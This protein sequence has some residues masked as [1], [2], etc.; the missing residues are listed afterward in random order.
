MKRVLSLALAA[1]LIAAAG[2]DDGN[3]TSCGAD[4]QLCNGECAYTNND[5]DNCGGCGNACGS[6]QQCSNSQ[7]VCAGGLTICGQDC[8]TLGREDN[9]SGCGDV[10]SGTEACV[11]GECVT[12]S[13]EECNGVDDDGDDQIDE[14]LSQP[15]VTSCGEGIETCVAGAW[16]DCD[17][18]EPGT[19]VCDED[20]NDCDGEVDEGVTTTYYRDADGDRYGSATDSVQDC[21][22]P[23]GYVDDRTDC[24]DANDDVHPGATEACDGVDN[25]CSGTPDDPTGGCTCTIGTDRDCGEGGDTGECSWGTQTCI[26]EG[27]GP[28]WGACTGGVRPV[29]ETCDDRD[30]DC[31]G[32]PDD[33]IAGDAYEGNNTCAV[34][35]GP[36]VID[37]N[38]GESS[39]EGTLY[40]TDGTQD[41]DWF[42]TRAAEATHLDCGFMDPQCYF[43]YVAT[44][45]PPAGADHARWQLCVQDRT[46]ADPVCGAADYEQCT[47]AS[48]WDGTSYVVSIMWQGLCAP[49]VGEDSKDLYL[50]VRRSGATLVADCTPYQL[51][52][53]FIYTDE[54]CE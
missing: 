19:E 15:C 31:D 5:H 14:G 42:V 37:E 25:D 20:D 50:V 10:C 29:A 40:S 44:L 4:Q 48:D 49:I 8:V 11:D 39:L 45:T 46:F 41:E 27:S 22:E 26:N 21:E 1:G 32:T 6:T 24:N 13:N 28:V 36:F 43:Y 3:V 47:D 54:V 38:Y 23:N 2:C 16:R 9:C 33:G 12:V 7:C 53:E 34:A 52:A 17:A 30:N 18:P 35:R 51:T